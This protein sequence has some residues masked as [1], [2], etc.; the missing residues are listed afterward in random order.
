M[1]PRNWKLPLGHIQAKL[2]SMSFPP[3]QTLPSLGYF[4]S[5]YTICEW[6]AI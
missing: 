3:Q 6:I 4:G 1:K 5:I 2:F